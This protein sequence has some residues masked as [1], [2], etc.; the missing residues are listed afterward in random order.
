M[1][2]HGEYQHCQWEEKRNCIF[3]ECLLQPMSIY[4]PNPMRACP[5]CGKSSIIGGTRK[6]LRGHYN[7]TKTERKYPNLQ[8]VRLAS[9]RRVKAC[10]RCLKTLHRKAG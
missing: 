10:T 9:G 6:L 1:E 2:H 4:R 8:W 7:L 5:L 3:H